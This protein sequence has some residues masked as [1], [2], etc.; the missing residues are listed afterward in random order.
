MA[1]TSPA[2][3]DAR[4][5]HLHSASA[6]I[7]GAALD[8]ARTVAA[9]PGVRRVSTLPDLHPGKHGPVG[10]TVVSDLLRPRLVGSDVGCG[11]ALFGLALKARKLR[12]E[13]AAERLRALD[14]PW[15][16]DATEAL[17]GAGLD[18]T[19]AAGL[20][21]IGGG[22]HF[23]EVQTVG[24][25]VDRDAASALGLDPDLCAL[26][27]H[28][29][30]R[31]HG[32]ALLASVE[33]EGDLAFPAGSEAAADYMLAHDAAVRWAALNRA[34]V[35][36]RAAA[37][38][39]CE[40]RVLTDVPHNLVVAVPDGFVHHKGAARA[41]AGQLRQVPVAGSRGTPSVLVAA[42]DDLAAS[43][44]AVSHGAGRKVDRAGMR[45]RAGLTRSD[46]ERLAR[47]RFGGRVVCDDRDLLVEEAPEA[48]KPIERVVADLEAF[49]LARRVAVLL[50]MVTFKLARAR[51]AREAG[52]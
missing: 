10:C 43:D 34:L 52:R 44:G 9:L 33:A 47:N 39:G 20:C 40:A 29:G 38:L 16:G 6:W 21:T 41:A 31:R 25:V 2:R 14:M 15:D 26:L 1:V 48:Y 7:E 24:E 3:A 8:Q 18:P 45:R 51:D 35:A 36:G 28:S 30:S 5:S 27:V 22:N 12:P 17:A 4:L 11:M 23:A 13:R 37:L 50:P 32:A 19:L 49:G 46:R 42:S